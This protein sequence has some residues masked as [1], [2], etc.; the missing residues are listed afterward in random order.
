MYLKRL[1]SEGYLNSEGNGRGKVYFLPNTHFDDPDEFSTVI[2]GDYLAS[3]INE[4]TPNI[5]S[6]LEQLDE[7]QIRQLQLIAQPVFNNARVKD[8][9][10]VKNTILEL[11]NKYTLTLPVLGIL[12]KR[13]E[14][15][16]LINYL[17]PMV[18]E[19]HTLRMAFPNKPNHPNQAY[20]KA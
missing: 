7:E 3:N 15:S 14:D 18:K 6:S 12:L 20:L 4:G 17:N 9:E 1:T 16:L 8:I 13:A 19:E 2:S 10:I 11:C 5:I